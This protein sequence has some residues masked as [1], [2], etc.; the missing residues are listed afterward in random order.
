MT[1]EE[2]KTAISQEETPSESLS[3]ELKALWCDRAGDWDGAHDIADGPPGKNAAWVH[4]YLHRVE[5]DNWNANYW[6]DRAGQ[7][8]PTGLSFEEEWEVLATYFLND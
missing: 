6:Y 4:A 2:F 7:T 8:M 5:G 1:L 3:L